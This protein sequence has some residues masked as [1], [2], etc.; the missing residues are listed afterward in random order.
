MSEPWTHAK[1]TGASWKPQLFHRLFSFPRKK[2]FFPIKPSWYPLELLLGASP[3][4]FLISKLLL[5]WKCTSV[6]PMAAMEGIR[7]RMESGVK[8]CFHS[9]EMA[10]FTHKAYGKHQRWHRTWFLLWT[11]QVLKHLMSVPEKGS[12]WLQG[13]GT[14]RC[15]NTNCSDNTAREGDYVKAMTWGKTC[16]KYLAS[17]PSE[18]ELRAPDRRIKSFRPS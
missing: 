12:V 7:K 3:W 14:G 2:L 6:N 17:S 10:Q 1:V 11:P 15:H 18:A 16:C 8:F 13:T 4:S 5:P 9:A